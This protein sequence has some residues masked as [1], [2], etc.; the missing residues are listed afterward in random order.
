MTVVPRGIAHGRH[1][2]GPAIALALVLR[3]R[4][5]KSATETRR[6]VSPWRTVGSAATGWVSLRRWVRAVREGRLFGGGFAKTLREIAARICAH[7]PP[8][9][10][11]SPLRAAFAGGA[12]MA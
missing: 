11:G 8:A 5:G 10:R 4:L 9:L 7:A 1:F 12:R 2:S 3:G 6:L